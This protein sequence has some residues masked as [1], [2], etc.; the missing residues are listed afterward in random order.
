MIGRFSLGGAL[1]R[2]LAAVLSAERYRL[3]LENCVKADPAAFES[4]LTMCSEIRHCH[5]GGHDVGL[6]SQSPCSRRREAEN[7]SVGVAIG[8]RPPAD[9][10]R[11]T[12]DDAVLGRIE[13]VWNCCDDLVP[14]AGEPAVPRGS[15]PPATPNR[16]TPT[17]ADA[18]I[19][20]RPFMDIHDRHATPKLDA[21]DRRRSCGA[22][23]EAGRI[24][25]FDRASHWH[26]IARYVD[27]HACAGRSVAAAR[28]NCIEE[29]GPGE[30]LGRD[31]QKT[32]GN[33]RA[34]Y[35]GAICTEPSQV[36]IAPTADPDMESAFECIGE[37]PLELAVRRIDL[38]QRL[39][40]GVMESEV[41]VAPANV[42]HDEDIIALAKFLEEPRYRVVLGPGASVAL[43]CQ[44]PERQSSASSPAK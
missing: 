10:V 36:V 5:V 4:H 16:P 41:R 3:M 13:R 1:V 38:D 23:R 35:S 6:E 8:R 12:L 32:T 33:T 43:T 37:Q 27:E 19:V 42:R 30:S 34:A 15:P 21:L 11:P 9:R 20:S 17:Y 29:S 24:A 26:A 44:L 40:A 28:T 7:D 18:V 22:I 14:D 25:Q 39:E 31:A 2:Q